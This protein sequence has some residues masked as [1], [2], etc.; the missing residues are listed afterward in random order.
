MRVPLSKILWIEP[1]ECAFAAC[2][3]QAHVL[4]G[5]ARGAALGAVGGSITGDAGEGA[6]AGDAMGGLAGN[7]AVE[8]PL[9]RIPNHENSDLGC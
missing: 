4:K 7:F 5:G 1:D 8:T 9:E 3:S 6:A 2:A